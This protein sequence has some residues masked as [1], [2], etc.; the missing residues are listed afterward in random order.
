MKIPLQIVGS[1][2]HRPAGAARLH[3]W[4]GAVMAAPAVDSSS[5]PGDAMFA[6]VVAMMKSAAMD[7]GG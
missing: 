6:I 5:A 7:D 1:L 3:K 2:D 4:F